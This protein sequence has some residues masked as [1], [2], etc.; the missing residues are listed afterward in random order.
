MALIAHTSAAS[1]D[2]NTVTTSGVNT[3]GATAL[4]AFVAY[5]GSSAPVPTDSNGNTWTPLTAQSGT[6]G[7]GRWFYAANPIVGS[8]HTASV[9]ASF[10]YPGLIFLAFSGITITSPFDQENGTGTSSGATSL[11]TGSVT[12]SE[13]GELILVGLSFESIISGLGID[14]TGFTIIETVPSVGGQNYGAAVAYKIQSTAAAENRTWSW[15]SSTDGTATIATFKSSGSSPQTVTMPLL[16]AVTL[17]A[18]TVSP[19]AVTLTAPLLAATTLFAPTVTAKIT[20]TAP[21][22][23]A[24]TMLPPTVSPGPR[25]LTLPLLAALTTLA[26]SISQPQ[27]LTAPLLA[28]LTMLTPVVGGSQTLTAPLL[29]ALTML[30]PTLASKITLTTPILAGATLLTPVISTSV[31]LGMPLLAALTLLNPSLTPG[32]VTLGM[33]LLA[34]GTLLVPILH[35]G[36]ELNP[37]AYIR[38]PLGPG[39]VTDALRTLAGLVGGVTDRLQ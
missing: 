36:V 8:G 15:T 37:E 7:R 31:G 9:N 25:A 34:A 35:G 4:A 1:L 18:P 14:G 21:L 22:L 3:T 29:G 19:G 38:I 12:P 32:A 6:F 17:L 16:S 5:D 11:A 24:L 20:L 27:T 10:S 2:G 13:N 39:G 23:V 28:A 30:V 26:P 33:P